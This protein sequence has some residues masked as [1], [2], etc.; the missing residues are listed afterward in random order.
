MLAGALAVNASTGVLTTT[1]T[2]PSSPSGGAIAATVAADNGATGVLQHIS[3]PVAA[4]S[5]APALAGYTATLNRGGLMMM[6]PLS[7]LK[8]A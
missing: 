5:G 1:V 8:A 7:S 4:T 6:A 3:V 2:A